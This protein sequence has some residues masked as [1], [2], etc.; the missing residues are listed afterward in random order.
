MR[1]FVCSFGTFISEL[2]IRSVGT[3]TSVSELMVHI[4][5]KLAIRNFWKKRNTIRF[6]TLSSYLLASGTFFH[7]LVLEHLQTHVSARSF[8]NLSFKNFSLRNIRGCA[9]TY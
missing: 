2:L 5:L 4:F 1:L 7:D 3:I 8:Q 6:V 9:Q